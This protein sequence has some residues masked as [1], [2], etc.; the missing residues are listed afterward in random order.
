MSSNHVKPADKMK[1][2]LIDAIQ[3]RMVTA[4]APWGNCTIRKPAG[5]GQPLIAEITPLMGVTPFTFEIKVTQIVTRLKRGVR[6]G[7][8]EPPRDRRDLEVDEDR[9]MRG[10]VND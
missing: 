8:G 5:R 10:I 1:A 6:L 2:L 4:G 3:N 7:S 9:L